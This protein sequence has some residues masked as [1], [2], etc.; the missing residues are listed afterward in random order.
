MLVNDKQ[1]V[2]EPSNSDDNVND[3]DGRM[4]AATIAAAK[5]I[6]HVCHESNI[7]LASVAIPLPSKDP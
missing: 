4:A 3:D 5:H 6:A 1:T 7:R 2:D